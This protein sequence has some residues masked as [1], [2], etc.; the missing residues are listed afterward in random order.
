MEEV[1]AKDGWRLCHV[2]RV[3][4]TLSKPVRVTNWSPNAQEEGSRRAIAFEA[5]V[6]PESVENR[7]ASDAEVLRELMPGPEMV[8][9]R[10]VDRF[11]Y[12]PDDRDYTL[13]EDYEALGS[14]LEGIVHGEDIVLMVRRDNIDSITVDTLR[15]PLIMVAPDGE[16]V[17]MQETSNTDG[18]DYDI[19][20]DEM[21]NHQ[22]IAAWKKRSGSTD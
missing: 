5:I 3:H 8:V 12:H 19:S 6:I 7:W 10:W 11:L 21:C 2:P 14:A 17:A 1:K 13:E 18:F 16:M 15:R 20:F 4:V 9:F 22:Q